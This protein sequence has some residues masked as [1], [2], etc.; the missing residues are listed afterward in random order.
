MRAAWITLLATLAFVAAGCGG[1]DVGAGRASGAEILRAGALVYWELESDPGSDQWKQVEEL[2]GRFPD[3]DKWIADLK[4]ELESEEGVTWEGDVK[5]ALGDQVAVAVYAKSMEDVSFVGLTNPEDPEKTVALVKKLDEGEAEGGPTFSR[6]VDDWVVISDK[7]ASIDASLNGE[8]GQSLADAEGFKNGMAELPEDALSRVYFDPAAAIEAFGDADA[9]TAKA[10]RMFGLDNLEFAGAWAKARDDGVEL[11]GAVRGEGADKLLGT[12]KSYASKFLERVPADAFA[13][14]SIQG[15]GLTQQFEAL[16]SNPLFSMGLRQAEA[17]LG[18]KID[19]IVRL[20][21]G[22]VAFYAAP[23]APIPALTLLLESDD[24]A[25]ARQSA[26]RLLEILARRG[27]GVIEEDG[28]V[29]TANFD[30]FTVNLASLEDALVLTTSKR[31]IDELGSSGEKLADSDRFKKALD[32]AGAPD[33]YTGLLYTDLA[34]AVELAMG[35]ADA[36]EANVPPAV[37]NN[38]KPLRSLVVYGEK[39]GDLASSLI[40]LEIAE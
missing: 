12:G 38:L 37:S 10:L 25:Q 40:F 30:G 33:E 14:Y 6:V 3:G 19:E 18:M 34:E 28:G 39:D 31:A 27:E 11:A 5:P 9:N 35:Y 32:A 4:K 29:T 24:P 20:F 8:G 22:E 21:E 13:F 36:A 7:Q 2:L 17:E 1:E 26:E 16:R 23:G 15:G